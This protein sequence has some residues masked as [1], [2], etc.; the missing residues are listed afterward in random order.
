[1]LIRSAAMQKGKY[2]FIA[3]G[4]LIV[5]LTATWAYLKYQDYSL[6]RQELLAA[7]YHLLCEVLKPGMSVD[8]VLGIL[9]QAGE[10]TTNLSESDRGQVFFD[11]NVN[12]IDKNGKDQYGGFELGFAHGGY[13]GAFI[14]G[15]DYYEPICILSR[16]TQSMTAT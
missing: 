11:F 7:R 2:I 13:D 5:L 4:L 3:L 1:M 8:D 12:F 15:F 16:P 6:K 14:S 10:F 9:R